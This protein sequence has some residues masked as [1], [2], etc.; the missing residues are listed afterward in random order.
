MAEH[1]PLW[2]QMA[3]ILLGPSGPTTLQTF[4][5]DAAGVLRTLAAIIEE[6]AAQGLDLDPGETAD[7]FRDEAAKAEGSNG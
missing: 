4:A 3:D 7:W 6:R 2:L 1:K 5:P